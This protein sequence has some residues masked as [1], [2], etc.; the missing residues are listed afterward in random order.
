M[1]LVFG[2]A[3]SPGVEGQT[4]AHWPANTKIS[5]SHGQPTLIMFAHPKCPCTRAS[6]Y[7]LAQVAKAIG[8]TF[9]AQVWFI[10]PAGTSNDWTNTSLWN[11]A[12]SIPGVAVYCDKSG[13]E[14]SRFQAGTSGETVLYDASGNL[15]FHG[16]I[17]LSRGHSGDNPALQEL[18]QLWQLGSAAPCGTR[19]YGCPLFAGKCP[20]PQTPSDEK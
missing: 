20:A 18:E 7:E 9:Y 10:K 5:A 6:L 4:P 15:L 2:Y 11:T 3:N 13:I 8:S 12:S 1:T 17:T 16:G 19:V 14:A